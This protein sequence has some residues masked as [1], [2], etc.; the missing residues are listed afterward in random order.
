MFIR[1]CIV[2]ALILRCSV[3]TVAAD[4]WPPFRG[5]R[6]NA[7]AISEQLPTEWNAEKNIAWKIML[8]GVGW[9]Q[10]VV[11]G[12]KIFLT[13]AITENQQKPRAGGGFGGPGGPGGGRGGFGPPGGTSR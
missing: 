7:I 8:P 13:T 10:P 12:D 1:S 6:G 2:I 11:W 4:E 3:L 9:S 5:P